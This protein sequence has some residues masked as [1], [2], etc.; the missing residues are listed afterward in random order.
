M[1]WIAP[2]LLIPA[3]AI[4][5]NFDKGF[6][7]GYYH[8]Q[9]MKCMK[10]YP[11]YSQEYAWLAK[12]EHSLDLVHRLHLDRL[13]GKAR[14][15]MAKGFKV[16]VSDKRHT[17]SMPHYTDCIATA[18]RVKVRT[19]PHTLDK[20]RYIRANPIKAFINKYTYPHFSF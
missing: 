18:H 11:A 20:K 1:K 19:E 13:S 6:D 3:I 15:A 14:S 12:W 10:S 4:A 8:G 2:L 16:G 5:D 17:L 7:L 9:N